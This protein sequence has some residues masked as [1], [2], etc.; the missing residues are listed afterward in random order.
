VKP[1]HLKI[2]EFSPTMPVEDLKS[3]V[4]YIKNLWGAE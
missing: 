3:G 1:E 2:F 4:D